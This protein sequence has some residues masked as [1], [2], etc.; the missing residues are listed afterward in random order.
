M[1][2]NSI[3][4]GAA[5]AS[6]SVW[7]EQATQQ[8]FFAYIKKFNK[9]YP[10]E[11]VFPRYNAFKTNL[12]LVREHNAGNH[13]WNMGLNQFADMTDEE[14]K[15]HM[16]LRPLEKSFFRGEVALTTEVGSQDIDWVAKG[17]VSPVWNQGQCG[18]CWAFS[19]TGAL[20]GAVQIATGKLTPLSNQQLVDCTHGV[21]NLGCDGGDIVPTYKWIISNQGMGSEASY[22]YVAQ[23]GTCKN[24]PSVSTMTGY[25]NIQPTESALMA[26]LL[27]QPVSIAI[28]ADQ[29]GFRFYESG[30]FKGECGRNL[31]RAVVLVGAGTDGADYW[32][33]KNSWGT[34]WGGAGVHPHDQVFVCI[35]SLL[36]CAQGT[37]YLR[38]C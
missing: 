31:D 22:P 30:V 24:V 23:D 6:A 7:Q 37:E 10:I 15:A 17:A 3:V 16:G 38:D 9:Q 14:F 33:V 35:C 19:V 13:G 5:V 11:E 12:K 4:F 25:K 28:E 18:S 27:Q 2:L 34:S 21:G 29:S 32:K 20:E 36:L 8:E 26:A 1:T